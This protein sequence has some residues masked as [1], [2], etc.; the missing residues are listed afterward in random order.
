MGKDS[1]HIDY[2]PHVHAYPVESFRI[3]YVVS[4]I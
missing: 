4:I 2:E 1:T 3:H